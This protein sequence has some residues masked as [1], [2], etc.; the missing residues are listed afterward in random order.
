MCFTFTFEQKCSFSGSKGNCAWNGIYEHICKIPTCFTFI[1]EQ[2]CSY[3]GSKGNG[4]WMWNRKRDKFGKS[5][6]VL[7]AKKKKNTDS[8]NT[9]G[10]SAG[11]DGMAK[12]TLYVRWVPEPEAE[13]S[14]IV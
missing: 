2:K 5:E 12:S 1:L 7:R 11:E 14:G 10:K 4:M 3:S 13:L 9:K 6:P 8:R